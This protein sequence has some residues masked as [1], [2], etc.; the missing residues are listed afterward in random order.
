[1]DWR[2]Y[3]WVNRLQVHTGWAQGP[4]RVYAKDGIV[5]FA[6][7]VLAGWWVARRRPGA[8]AMAAAVWAPIAAACGLGVNQVIG[9]LVDRARPCATHSGR[10]H[11][12]R[13]NSGLLLPKRPRRRRQCGGGRTLVRRPSPS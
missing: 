11:P 7:A 8:E 4:L 13:P 9:H 3:K 10:P 1:M 12:D 6:V 5:L 2:L